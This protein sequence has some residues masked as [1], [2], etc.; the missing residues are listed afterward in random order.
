[1]ALTE[2]PP[3]LEWRYV[4]NW[5]WYRYDRLKSWFFSSKTYIL[6]EVLLYREE[7]IYRRDYIQSSGLK[8]GP[9]Y[10]LLRDF[11]LRNFTAETLVMSLLI[12]MIAWRCCALVPSWEAAS[13]WRCRHLPKYCF[14][15]QT[16]L[17][18]SWQSYQPCIPFFFFLLTNGYLYNRLPA[19]LFQWL[20]IE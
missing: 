20:V 16:Y 8:H 9:S 4:S 5:L 7:Y 1:M 2:F 18:I 19:K 11:Y 12:V 3:L 14:R 15:K 10:S 6:Y 17:S 13:L